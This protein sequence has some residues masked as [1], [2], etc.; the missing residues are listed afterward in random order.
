MSMEGTSA[1]LVLPI[2]WTAC[3][4][5]ESMSVEKLKDPEAGAKY[6]GIL[7]GADQL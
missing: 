5:E 6:S 2:V 7:H 4:K 3:K 1:G